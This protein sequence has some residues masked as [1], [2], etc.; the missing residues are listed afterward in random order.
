MAGGDDGLPRGHAI[1][2]GAGLAEARGRPAHAAQLD[3]PWMPQRPSLK[4]TI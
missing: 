4:V 3:R 1:L 2:F